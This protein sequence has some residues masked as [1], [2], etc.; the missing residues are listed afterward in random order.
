MIFRLLI[1]YA[2]VHL[3]SQDLSV[4]GKR[5]GLEGERSGLFMEQ[6]R[7]VKEMREHDRQSADGYF[8]FHPRPEF[9][10]WE[11]VPGAFSSGKPKGSD[12]QA[13]LTEIVRIVEPDASTMSWEN[14]AWPG[15]CTMPSGGVFLKD[16]SGLLL[17][18][19]FADLT[20]PKCYLEINCGE[21]PIE[22]MPTKL[23]QILEEN[24]DPKYQLSARA[25]A[26]IL[27]RA[28]KRGKE[29]PEILKMAL[30]N[31]VRTME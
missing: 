16:G 24:A 25:C 2:V 15:S 20:Q 4:A 21:S 19:I 23:S 30:E 17:L 7:V 27:N 22:P 12:F 8:R 26:G 3:V 5:E 29:L 18:P 13:V 1:L 14:G 10:V 11:N 31:Q 6:L 9:M 28:A